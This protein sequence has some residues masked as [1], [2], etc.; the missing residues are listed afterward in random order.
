MLLAAEIRKS[1][2]LLPGSRK[3]ALLC[4]P[5]ERT[6]GCVSVNLHSDVA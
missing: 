2:L 6:F 4:I 1:F 3:I 5:G